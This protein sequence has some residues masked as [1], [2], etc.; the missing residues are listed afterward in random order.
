MHFNTW[1][2]MLF[3]SSLNSNLYQTCKLDLFENRC[4]W[5]RDHKF[6]GEIK[7]TKTTFAKQIQPV[8][9][10]SFRHFS[11]PKIGPKNWTPKIGL[12]LEFDLWTHYIILTIQTAPP[13]VTNGF[14][15]PHHQSCLIY[16]RQYSGMELRASGRSGR[17]KF[18]F[19][20]IP[21]FLCFQL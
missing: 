20:P 3:R 8:I 9:L 1:L 10:T 13:S 21:P 15:K 5:T 7:W 17:R 11:G 19:R 4:N 6:R 12:V 14:R 2:P 18:S 16:F